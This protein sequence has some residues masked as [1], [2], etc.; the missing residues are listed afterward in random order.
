M[1]GYELVYQKW[2]NELQQDGFDWTTAK[3]LNSF[4]DR[5]VYAKTGLYHINGYA[6]IAMSDLL[7]Q[8]QETENPPDRN[9]DLIQILEYTIDPYSGNWN[10]PKVIETYRYWKKGTP[11]V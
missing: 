1:K 6:Q 9:G 5:E 3:V 4:T 2:H 8:D 11:D 10:N 7:K